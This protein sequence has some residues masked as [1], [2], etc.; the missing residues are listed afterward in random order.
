MQEVVKKD[1]IKWLDSR[2]VYSISDNK[3][4]SPF[5]CIPKKGGINVVVNEKNKLI[6]LSPVV[7]RRV[8]MYYWKLKSWHS[9]TITQCLLWIK[10]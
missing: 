3:W 5:Q 8:C 2:V 10:Y 6:P 4:V 7:G 9:E 1:I